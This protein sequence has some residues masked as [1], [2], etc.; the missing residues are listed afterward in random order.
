MKIINGKPFLSGMR[1]IL[2]DNQGLANDLG[3]LR[4]IVLD[5]LNINLD[6]L[7]AVY[8]AGLVNA[9]E[10]QE[11]CDDLVGVHELVCTCTH[12]ETDKMP[13]VVVPEMP[14]HLKA[15]DNHR[16]YTWNHSNP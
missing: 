12:R 7:G 3:Q 11:G 2:T 4:E 1:S 6:A 8:E 14:A 16:R 9:A 13:A 15:L 5:L 10:Y